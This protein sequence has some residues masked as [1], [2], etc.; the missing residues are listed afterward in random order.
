MREGWTRVALGD[1]ITVNPASPPLAV[2]APFIPM[3]AVPVGGRFP[4][5]SERRGERSGARAQAGDTL[6]ARITPCLENG[7]IAQ[8]PADWPACGGSTE[9]ITLRATDSVTPDFVFLLATSRSFRRKAEALMTGTTGRQR[10]SAPDIA[11]IGLD[12]PPLEE[13]RRIVDLISSLDA[14][15]TATDHAVAKAE[16]ARRAVLN[17]L[18]SPPSKADQSTVAQ[19]STPLGSNVG[20]TRTTLGE[21]ATWH[22]G[23]TPKA[24]DRRFYSSTREGYPW[25]VIADLAGGRVDTTAGVLTDAGLA[26]IGGRLAPSGAVLVSMYGSIGRVAVAGREMATNQAIAWAEARPDRVDSAFLALLVG[27][28]GPAMAA[29]GR[30]ATQKNINRQIIKLWPITL[31]PLDEQRRI[32]EIVSA[33]D[34]EIVALKATAK[35]ARTARPGMLSDLLSGTHE[36]PASYDRLLDAA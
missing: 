36:I 11:S 9:L 25:A 1:V 14:T 34:D 15:I 26:E 3:D 13:Q 32:V 20:W 4:S 7:K 17:D 31:P 24:G 21:I 22:S 19:D 2:D 18:L 28:L 33:L 12:L 16:Q 5:Y 35:A 8:V 29:I 30:G 27:H 6:L 10:V 23:G